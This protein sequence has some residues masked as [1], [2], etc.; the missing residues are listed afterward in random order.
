MDETRT[1][2]K[3]QK[4]FESFCGRQ[5]T[6]DSWREARRVCV[7]HCSQGLK[8]QCLQEF[9]AAELKGHFASVH[10]RPGDHCIRKRSVGCQ[11]DPWGTGAFSQ[12]N[13]FLPGIYMQQ[14]LQRYVWLYRPD[15][16]TTNQSSIV[17][18]I[19]FSFDGIK[20]VWEIDSNCVLFLLL[21]YKPIKYGHFHFKGKRTK[22]I[23]NQLMHISCS[24]R[25]IRVP[26]RGCV[27]L[28]NPDISRSYP[29]FANPHL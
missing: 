5:P 26:G 6:P 9:C 29:V 1:M 16:L 25:V 15:L 8:A 12:L 22:D 4:S 11:V 28:F 14:H 24:Y 2:D 23:L 17:H 21:F 7:G 10:K 18:W 3:E 13:T 19:A 20:H 27:L